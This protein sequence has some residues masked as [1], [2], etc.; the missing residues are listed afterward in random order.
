M[1]NMIYSVLIYVELQFLCNNSIIILSNSCEKGENLMKKNYVIVVIMTVILLFSSSTAYAAESSNVCTG[2]TAQ[3]SDSLYHHIYDYGVSM[4]TYEPY[5]S[6][7]FKAI[8]DRVDILFGGL[9]YSI[10]AT[11]TYYFEELNSNGT[12]TVIN[13]NTV[14]YMGSM[15]T[16]I[17]V[18]PNNT[19]RVRV[20]TTDKYNGAMF[21]E[22][23]EYIYD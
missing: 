23:F 14:K 3:E 9:G 11:Y 17:Y 8:T 19:Y 16:T 6:D 15:G 18:T 10:S 12:W 21:L 4:T 20:T 2:F 5:T 1:E 7:T 13:S 22:V